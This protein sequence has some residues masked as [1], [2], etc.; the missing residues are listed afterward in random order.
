MPLCLLLAAAGTIHC[1]SSDP[2]RTGFHFQPAAHP[3]EYSVMNDPNGIFRD[4]RGLFHMFAQFRYT[5]ASFA[6]AQ[7]SGVGWLHAVSLDSLAW[8]HLPMALIPQA[9]WECGGIFSGSAT[10]VEGQPVLAYAVECNEAI[11]LAL[12]ANASDPLLTAWEKPEYDPAVRHMPDYNFRDPVTA[13]HPADPGHPPAAEEWRMAVGCS[14]HLCTFRSADFKSWRDAGIMYHVPG[15][16]MWEC[17]GTL[18]AVQ[19]ASCHAMPY[20]VSS[21]CHT[22]T[23]I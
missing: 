13:F 6:E 4:H 17:P 16:H 12:P 18:Y 23:L 8:T 14:G 1:D 20:H 9:P 5:N 15:Q 2:S 11:G 21:A 7:P 3:T 19:A 22:H 10:W